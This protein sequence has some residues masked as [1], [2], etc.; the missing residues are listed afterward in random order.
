MG[1]PDRSQSALNAVDRR[2]GARILLVT[3]MSGAGRS[4]ALRFLED[5]GYE[6]VD[7]LPLSLLPRLAGPGA[8]PIAVGIDIRTR[9]FAAETV[10]DEFTRLAAE[11]GRAVDLVFLDC[12]DQVLAR[13]YTE[14]R[15]RHPLAGDRP[16]SDGIRLE[17]ARLA[18]LRARAGLV[19]DTSDMRAADLKR[20]LSGHFAR[21]KSPGLSV[22]VTSFSYRQGLPRDADLV[23]DVRFLKNPYYQP[24]LRALTGLDPAVGD[25]VA[26]DPAWTQFFDGLTRFLAPLLRQFSGEG[27]SYLTLAVGCTGGHHRSVFAAERLTHWLTQEGYPATAAHRDIA[28]PANPND[29]GTA[30]PVPGEP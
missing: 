1:E 6:A 25:F 30:P 24:A 11:A 26:S 29:I 12:D 3:G 27:K 10:A 15:R 2:T 23:F 20:L 7:N 9:D 14:T 16:V 4:T 17:R 18:A 19:I 5:M 22:F 28:G 13:R 8:G 21:D